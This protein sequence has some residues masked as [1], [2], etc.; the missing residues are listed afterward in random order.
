LRW[1][2]RRDSMEARLERTDTCGNYSR[3]LANTFWRGSL[4]RIS[5]IR[6]LPKK[7]IESVLLGKAIA[8]NYAPKSD[9][10]N[11]SHLHP[12][13][14]GTRAWRS[15]DMFRKLHF[16]APKPR[17]LDRFIFRHRDN[18]HCILFKL[19]PETPVK[20]R[21]L[22]SPLPPRGMVLHSI[23]CKTA[24]LGPSKNERCNR[25]ERCIRQGQDRL[26]RTSR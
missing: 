13:S 4:T 6:P 23:W 24:T 22:P 16:W 15:P 5:R 14:S 19:R 21:T 1:L 7:S 2:S 9:N 20:T 18:K 26:V 10:R 12:R 11:E 25:L 8:G 3:N 17:L